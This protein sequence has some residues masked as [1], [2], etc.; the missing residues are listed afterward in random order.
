M[1]IKFQKHTNNSQEFFQI[2]PLDWQEA[3]HMV[4]DKA[5]ATSEIYVIKEEDEIIAGGILFKQYTQ[6]MALLKKTAKQLLASNCYYIGYLWVNETH[7][8]KDLGTFWLN[9]I[10][11]A[12]PKNNFWL[13]IEEENLQKFYIKNGFE[14]TQKV[15]NVDGEEWLMVYSW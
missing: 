11:N 1:S 3:L 8:G 9:S 7:R 15:E 5:K 6:D 10:K 14:L 13:T 2:L 12:Y 4:W